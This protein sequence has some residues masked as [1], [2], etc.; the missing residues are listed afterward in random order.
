MASARGFCERCGARLRLTTRAPDVRCDAC[1]R[2]RALEDAFGDGERELTAGARE[3]KFHHGVEARHPNGTRVGATEEVTRE[4]ATV[5]EKC[6][7]CK[8]KGLNFYTM[9][10]RSADEG[11][12]VFYECPKC[13]HTFSQNN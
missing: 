1:G 3:F 12:T 5:D 6:P 8:H 9:Q 10:L 11:Q 13:S 4:R 2:A 7:K